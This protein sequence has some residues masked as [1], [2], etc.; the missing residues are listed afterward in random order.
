[1]REAAAAQLRTLFEEIEK[2][3]GV[4]PESDHPLYQRDPEYHGFDHLEALEAGEIDRQ[5]CQAR[6]ATTTQAAA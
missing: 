5:W 2:N 6:T 4:W 1:M 3:T